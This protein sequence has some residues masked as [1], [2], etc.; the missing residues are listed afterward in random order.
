MAWVARQ[1]P[2]LDAVQAAD[3]LLTPEILTLIAMVMAP[4]SKRVKLPPGCAKSAS[5]SAKRSVS[6]R[7]RRVCKHCSSIARP[8]GWTSA[9]WPMATQRNCSL[10]WSRLRAFRSPTRRLSTSANGSAGPTWFYCSYCYYQS[11]ICWIPCYSAVER[12][13]D[14]HLVLRLGRIGSHTLL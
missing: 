7:S 14:K 13:P 10:P 4:V 1:R 8:Q 3:R 11:T 5:G 6:R 12:L 9:R 2:S